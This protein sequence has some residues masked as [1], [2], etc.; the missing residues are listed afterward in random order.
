MK[1]LKEFIYLKYFNVYYSLKKNDK[2]IEFL[3]LEGEP[4]IK[5]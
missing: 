2:T 1:F 5:L 3:I 4:C